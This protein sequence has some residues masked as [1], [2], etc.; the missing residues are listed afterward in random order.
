MH[1]RSN[2]HAAT[3]LSPI[4][5]DAPWNA[6][7]AIPE[8][9]P[10]HTSLRSDNPSHEPHTR[11]RRRQEGLNSNEAS[12]QATHGAHTSFSTSCNSISSPL[13]RKFGGTDISKGYRQADRQQSGS[14]LRRPLTDVEKD[15]R[16]WQ[17]YVF[18]EDSLGSEIADCSGS[19]N[20]TRLDTASSE[21]S[22]GQILTSLAGRLS[23]DMVTP[24]NPRIRHARN[25]SNCIQQ[26]P[27]SPTLT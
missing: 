2:W 16:M 27:S 26:T 7:L 8:D 17:M 5:D 4:V 9:N 20:R 23:V 22:T 3:L 14:G 1:G 25:V 19:K 11:D 18:D 10:S 21:K 12:Q 6:F 15:E 13:I 24:S